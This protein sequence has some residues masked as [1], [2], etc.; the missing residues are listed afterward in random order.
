[1]F[2]LFRRAM[3]KAAKRAASANVRAATKALQKLAG[4]PRETSPKATS[5]GQVGQG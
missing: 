5:R 1:M 2:K 3:A 4:T